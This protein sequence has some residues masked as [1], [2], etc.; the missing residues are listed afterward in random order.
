MWQYLFWIID[1]YLSKG[2]LQRKCE[3]FERTGERNWRPLKGIWSKGRSR[4]SQSTFWLS[5]LYGHWP[6]GAAPNFGK[7]KI[8][9]AMSAP[10][11]KT[12]ACAAAFLDRVSVISRAV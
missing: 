11:K 4:V 12:A 2:Q 1:F 6:V 8:R 9:Q 7:N 3:P 5:G 10:D